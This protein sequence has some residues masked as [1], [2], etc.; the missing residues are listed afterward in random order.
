MLDPGSGLGAL[1][2]ALIQR[3]ITQRIRV[4][5]DLVLYEKD[6]KVTP[7]LRSVMELCKKRCMNVVMNLNIQ[8]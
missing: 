6:K 5:I 3:I 4:D 7:H 8:S 1:S 2:G